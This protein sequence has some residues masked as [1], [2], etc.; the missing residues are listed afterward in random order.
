MM[1]PPMEKGE[2]NMSQAISDVMVHIV[3]PL[4]EGERERLEQALTA[5][6]GVRSVR[7]SA[8]GP[9]LVLVDYD[10]RVISALGA[11]RSFR[12]LGLEASLI[13]L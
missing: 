6:P 2:M 10:P 5:A 3:R 7:P 8:R 12:S 9:Q 13:G 4:R 11:L 1:A